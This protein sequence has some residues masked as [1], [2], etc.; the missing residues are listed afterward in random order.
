MTE[1]ASPRQL[2][3]AFMRWALVCVPAIL[4]L[5]TISGRIANSDEGNPWFEALAKPALMPPAWVF[6]A[7]WS[8]LY[9]LMALALAMILHARG[10]R[11]RGVA[12]TLFLIQLGLPG[13]V[14]G[15]LRDAQDHAG[16]LAYR[17]HPAMGGC[18]DAGFLEDPAGSGDVDAALS[19]VAGVRGGA[20]L[21]D[22]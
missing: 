17:L 18:D 14:A 22:P 19:G 1:L 2:R 6:G 8:I 5:G 16:L 12:I 4:L 7:V 9:V 3:V 20:E 15:V 13:V 21:A 10:A 11:G